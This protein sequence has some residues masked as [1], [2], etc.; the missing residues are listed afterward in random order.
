MS[1]LVNQINA[2]FKDVL[3]KTESSQNSPSKIIQKIN[4][5]FIDRGCYLYGKKLF[6]ISLK[7]YFIDSSQAFRIKNDT[8]A[9]TG[10]VEK[11]TDIFFSEPELRPL[12][13]LTPEESALVTLDPGLNRNISFAR[14]VVLLD[15]GGL[16]F[17]EFNCDC[18][19]GP[20]YADIQTEIITETDIMQEIRSRWN[21]QTFRMLPNLLDCL[22]TGYREFCR[23]RNISGRDTPTIA[24][25]GGRHSRTLPEFHLIAE[26]I[27][28]QG[29]ACSF[30]DPSELGC[31]QNLNLVNED[32]TIID[33]IYRRGILAHWTDHPLETQNLRTA[34]AAGRVCVINS[35]RSVLGSRK[36]ITALIQ[37]KRFQSLFTEHERHFI[38]KRLP[39]TRLMA[40]EKTENW[41]GDTCDLFEFV[42]KNKD[43]LVLKPI[44]GLGGKDVCVGI[45]VDQDTWETSIEKTTRHEYIVQKYISI[46]EDDYPFMTPDVAWEP[47]RTNLNLFTYDQRF[48]GGF[49]RFSSDHIIN[50]HKDGGMACLAIVNDQS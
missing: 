50:I 35:P 26:W 37:E 9:L 47:R 48:T 40:Q 23:N 46:P 24:I 41:S 3:A 33:I 34:Y 19:G 15:Q 44:S 4:L 38:R 11:F 1:Q 18:P 10:I 36:H 16:S 14:H 39:W 8:A 7:P 22:L 42:R 30:H 6:P 27:Q 32:G 28:N 17:I 25:V 43:Y 13:K 5:D 45:A 2:A 29:Y 21:V 49:A 20:M 31:D 12:F